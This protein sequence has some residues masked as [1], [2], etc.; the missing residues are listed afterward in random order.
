[1]TNEAIIKTIESQIK[2]NDIVLYMKGTREMPQCGFSSAVSKA[3]TDLQ[4]QYETVNVLDNKEIR[5]AI[6]QYTDWP[7]IP[8][9]Y[10]KGEFVGGF[11]IVKE[12][13]QSGELQT[14]LQ[15]KG[16]LSTT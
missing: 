16:L 6:K 11:D 14:L 12:M 13:H 5:D 10:I 9:L 4:L 1:M 7:T 8:Q 2:N 15:Q 3:L